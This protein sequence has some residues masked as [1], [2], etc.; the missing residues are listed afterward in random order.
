M[1]LDLFIMITRWNDEK[2][3]D[4]PMSFTESLWM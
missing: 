3:K 4:D 2:E 1:S